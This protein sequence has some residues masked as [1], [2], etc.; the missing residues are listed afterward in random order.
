[1]VVEP[2]VTVKLFIVSLELT[3]NVKLK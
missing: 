1:M 3:V 2:L